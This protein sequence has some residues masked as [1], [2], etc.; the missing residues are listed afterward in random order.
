MITL[1]NIIVT[2]NQG[3]VNEFNALDKFNLTINNG[4]FVVIIGGNG[5]GKSTLMNVIAGNVIPQQGAIFFDNMDVTK[6]GVARRARMV[7]RVFQDP[8]Q[9][10]FAELTIA[11]NYI[12][13]ASRVR[14]KSLSLYNT[15]L[16]NFREQVAELNVGLED[17]F[18]QPIGM[19]SGGQRQLLALIM[20][21]SAPTQVLLLDEHTAALDPKIA[22]VVMELTDKLIKKHNV[23]ALMITHNMKH[24][25]EYGGRTIVMQHGKIMHD[26]SGE[27]KKQINPIKLWQETQEE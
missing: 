18:D 3:S 26:I 20:S 15:S 21:M 17:R 19:L 22:K 10:T 25:T 12:L 9:G 11:E 23:T 7:S 6:L 14:A 16:Q 5:A 1:K 2:F 24:A 27:E 8:L 4:E 13:F